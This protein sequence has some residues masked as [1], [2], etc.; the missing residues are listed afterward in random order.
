MTSVEGPQPGRKR[1]FIVIGAAA[2]VLV[3]AIVLAAVFLL[4]HGVTPENGKSVA[5][6]SGPSASPA[7]TTGATPAPSVAPSETP[8]IAA[9]DSPATGGSTS[10]GGSTGGGSAA[11]PA[12]AAP[13][14]LPAPPAPIITPTIQTFTVV[15]FAEPSKTIK[16]SCDADPSSELAV[17]VHWSTTNVSA[18]IG[19]RTQVSGSP[20]IDSKI[21]GYAASGSNH[22]FQLR[23]SKIAYVT[24]LFD[25]VS[26]HRE[27][28]LTID[29]QGDRGWAYTI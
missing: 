20:P 5:S 25:S 6:G 23:C 21:T 10:G 4:P 24:M 15:N 14:P 8:A 1:L 12:P 13:A 26:T 27:A 29:G 11:Q 22:R 19:F 7:A 28:R 16:Q 3:I 2:G 17:E 9:P 18:P